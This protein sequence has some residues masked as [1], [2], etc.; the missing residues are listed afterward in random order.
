VATVEIE[1][2]SRSAYVGVVR[3]ALSALGRSAGLDE[4]VVDDLKIAVSE[5]CA[6]AVL[7]A[8]IG[9]ERGRFDVEARRQDDLLHVHVRDYGTGM[10]PNPDSPGLGM[11]LSI[12]GAIA[13]RLEVI[14]REPG[15]EVAMAFHLDGDARAAA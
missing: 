12:I 3:L 14:P 11:G 5:A 10:R 1:V 4:D 8:Y 15:T 7:H 9:C 2:P 13:A 6:N